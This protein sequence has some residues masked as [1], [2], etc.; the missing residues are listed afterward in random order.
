MYDHL[1]V[2]V[3]LVQV[4]YLRRCLEGKTPP[5]QVADLDGDTTTCAS[6]VFVAVAA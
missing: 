6:V 4:Q 1:T 5:V 3:A 2:Q